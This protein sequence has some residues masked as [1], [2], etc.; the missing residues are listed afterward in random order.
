M[1]VFVPS[2][3]R[4]HHVP[5]MESLAGNSHLVWLVPEDEEPAYREAGAKMVVTGPREKSAKINEALDRFGNEWCVFSDDDCHGL[6]RL[7]RN[8]EVVPL[9]LGDAANHFVAA[10][11][12]HREHLVS[13]TALTNRHFMG[14]SV[15]P[16]G[17]TVGW[18]FAV[19]PGTSIRLDESLPTAEDLDFAARCFRRYGSIA[20]PNYIQGDYRVGGQ[21]SHF[22][23]SPE[24]KAAAFAELALRYPE[25]F[26]ADG[27]KIIY[28][29]QRRR[30][31]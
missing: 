20:R 23:H 21:D 3:G 31:R 1:R 6:V 19:A 28:L 24:A 12:R 10:G 15:T 11:R 5:R 26:R 2:L 14:P 13:I 17:Q 27:D 7:G 29:R 4:A 8:Q 30:A 9:T 16:W 22:D 25:L 18:F